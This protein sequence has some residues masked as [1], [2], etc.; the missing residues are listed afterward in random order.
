MEILKSHKGPIV[1]TFYES[2]PKP[3]IDVVDAN[4]TYYGYAEIATNE[5]E[6]K[7]MIEKHVKSGTVTKV[8]YPNAS[9]EFSFAWASRATYTYSR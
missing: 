3:F 9:M 7:W 5:D 1:K 8:L 6:E 2:L 4:N